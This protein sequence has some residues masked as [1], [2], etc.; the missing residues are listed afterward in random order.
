MALH[1]RQGPHK[2][3]EIVGTVT[4]HKIV[5]LVLFCCTS[6]IMQSPVQLKCRIRFD[7]ARGFINDFRLKI[8]VFLQNILMFFF[9]LQSTFKII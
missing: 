1:E 3:I 8:I 9:S 6:N 4:R 7:C 2:H 5:V